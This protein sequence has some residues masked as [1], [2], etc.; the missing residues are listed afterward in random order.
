MVKIDARLKDAMTP[1][2]WRP[3]CPVPIRRL[4][5]LRF[6]HFD[7]SGHVKPGR[8]VI[9]RREARKVLGVMR[10]LYEKGFP[11]RKAKLIERFDGS[12]HRSMDADNTSAFNCRFVNGTSRWSEHAYGL[13]IDINPIENPY[14]SGSHV[15]PRAGRRYADRSRRSK[16]MV[17]RGDPVFRAF[18]RIGWGWGG[19]WSPAQDFQ[20]FE[21]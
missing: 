2:A 5:L 18:K 15:S 11:I 1:D 6:S 9:N 19:T 7:F 20:H 8:L 10:K 4:R 16:G 12:D 13:A 17:H 14:V 21:R 3:G